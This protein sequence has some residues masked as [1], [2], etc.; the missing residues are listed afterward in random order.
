MELLDTSKE[1][2]LTQNGKIFEEGD[3]V[4]SI[5]FI[6]EGEIQIVKKIKEDESEK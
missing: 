2:K 3:K 1:I 4:D 5:Y 6:K